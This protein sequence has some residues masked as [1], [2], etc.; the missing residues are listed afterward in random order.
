MKKNSYHRSL[1]TCS[2]LACSVLIAH[3]LHAQ[4]IYNFGVESGTVDPTSDTI[5]NVSAGPLSSANRAEGS[6]ATTANST[7]SSGYPGASG[8]F[9]YVVN[10]TIGGVLSLATSTYITFA[11]TPATGFAVELSD[12]D[13]GA[14]MANLS[15]TPTDYSIYASNDAFASSPSN[16]GTGSFNKASG[17]GLNTPTITS[18]L[19]FI[20]AP[21]T[22]RVYIYGG[23]ED[24]TAGGNQRFDDITIVAQ[25]VPEPS[26]LAFLI[27]VS[28]TT[29]VMFLRRN[30]M[31]SS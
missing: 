7:A 26:T 13:F 11:L 3:S 19:G 28:L 29:L 5:V 14:R 20:D 18:F 15:A 6:T 30:G 31:L 1:I 12:I 16:I 27:A 4:I 9:N 2:V 24:S 21:V 22:V 23:N 8:N 25:A 17:W 10:G